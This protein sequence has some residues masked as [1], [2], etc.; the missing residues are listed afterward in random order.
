MNDQEHGKKLHE[1]MIFEH[2]EIGCIAITGR[3]VGGADKSES[4]D[5]LTEIDGIELGVEVAEV[6]YS[7]HYDHLVDGFD[8]CDY[9]AHV[10]RIA[11]QKNQSY[12]RRNIFKIP[13][14]LILYSAN[15]ALFDVKEYL[16]D[17][18]DYE[19]YDGLDFTEVWIMDMSD[20]YCSL[21]DPRRPP[22][23]FGLKPPDWRGFHRYGWWDRK[24][25]G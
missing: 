20:E 9:W 6:P 1:E 11:D 24:P 16:E 8:A 13:I 15:P 4:P 10:W 19:D 22:D 5:F 12:L 2:F 3:K 18:V 17:A 23:M 7:R 25:F 21:G 14:L